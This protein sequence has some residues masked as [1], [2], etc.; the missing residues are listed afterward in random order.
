MNVTVTKNQ[1]K[2]GCFKAEANGA[3][4]VEFVGLRRRDFIP[5]Q[6]ITSNNDAGPS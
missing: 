1:K 4:P 2:L 5:N 6:L 3:P